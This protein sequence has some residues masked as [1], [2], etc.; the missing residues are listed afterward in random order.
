MSIFKEH[1]TIADRS[2]SDRRRHKKKIEDAIR[3]GVHN[4]VADESIIGQDG[5]KKIKIPV[6]GIKEYRFV[7]G[8]NSQNKKVGSAPGKDIKRG[9]KVGEAQ[10]QQ[11]PGDKPGD[12]KGEEYYEVEISLEELTYYLFNDLELPDLA[13][14]TITNVVGEKFKRHGYRS[15][16]IRPRLDK[17]KTAINRIKRKKA[18]DLRKLRE[19]SLEN[20]E[21]EERFP[22]H[23]NDLKYRH[24]KK[25]VKEASNAVIFFLMD[26]SGSMTQTKKFLAR[27][28]YF[29]LYHFINNRYENC[30][31]VFVAHD[32]AAYE[33]DED[34]FF[35]RGNSGGTIVSAGLEKVEDIINKRYHPTSWNIYCFQCS[36][37]DNWPS[38]TDK[39]LGLISRLKDV[40][41]LFGYCEIE[42]DG[43]RLSWGAENKLAHV[44][45][46]MID[47]NFKVVKINEKEDI[48]PAFK[49]LLGKRVQEASY[50]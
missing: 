8:E 14:K 7:Y 24:I 27:S 49:K 20:S 40:C 11:G 42:P 48:W 19:Q 33:V 28:F 5:K 18:S 43:E 39:T 2:A 44:Y 26:I 34:K 21:E 16:G 1:K 23:Q 13:R 32:T 22:Y 36:D 15:Q 9:Q 41:Q 38:D 45:Q 17:K 12:G 31:V 29:L 50:G 47:L 6:R 46:K 25:D 35:K 37:G 10:K 3:D 30:E 4:I